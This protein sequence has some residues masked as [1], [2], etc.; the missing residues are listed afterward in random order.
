MTHPSTPPAK[1]DEPAPAVIVLEFP[2]GGT[3]H[4]VRTMGLEE[5]GIRTRYLFDEIRPRATAIGDYAR[6]LYDRVGPDGVEV[7]VAYC[8]A[9]AVARSVAEH[10]LAE[11]GSRPR[12]IA[13]NPEPTLAA[14]VAGLLRRTLAKIT[15]P[16]DLVGIRAEGDTVRAD[17]A[18]WLPDI[19]AKL[20]ESYAG[21]PLNLSPVAG[22][23]AAMQMDWLAHVTATCDPGKLPP[24][25]DEVHLVARDH[26]CEP[27]CPAEHE[28]VDAAGQD[29]FTDPETRRSLSELLGP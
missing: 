24:G 8:G 20:A 16:G 12:L 13:L 29:F 25:H 18:R 21:P 28:V 6:H 19:E 1:G 26:P 9:I 2:G 5:H 17:I 23:L 10:C 22:Q 7:V 15:A 27:D 4:R 3:A 11:R 14:G